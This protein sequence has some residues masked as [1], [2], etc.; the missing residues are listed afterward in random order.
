ML[1]L[2]TNDKK[3]QNT[4]ASLTGAFAFAA[5]SLWCYAQTMSLDV[6]HGAQDGLSKAAVALAIG[7]LA[8]IAKGL[9]HNM[10]LGAD[11]RII[12]HD[13]GSTTYEGMEVIARDALEAERSDAE[14]L[15]RRTDI[16]FTKPFEE[17]DMSGRTPVLA[18]VRHG[19]GEHM[20]PFYVEPSWPSELN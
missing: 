19:D 20:Y 7:S 12:R 18:V 8:W 10:N 5:G 2:L 13:D 3:K 6:S 15:P 17:R 11:T 4:I 16:L 14:T 1:S 9:G